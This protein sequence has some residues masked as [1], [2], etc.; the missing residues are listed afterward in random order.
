MSPIRTFYVQA[1]Q[2]LQKGAAVD[3]LTAEMLHEHH[4]DAVFRWPSPALVESKITQVA[5]L[6]R[7]CRL[8][9]E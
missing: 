2:C 4:Y 6:C 5:T 8:S 9:V 3:P 1:Q 7:P